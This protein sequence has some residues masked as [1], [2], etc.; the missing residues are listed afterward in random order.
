MGNSLSNNNSDANNNDDFLKSIDDIA[1]N[2]IFKQNIVDMLRFSDSNYRENFIILTC[3]LLDKKLS[4]VDIEIIKKRVLNEDSEN[5]INNSEIG[6]MI[7][8]SEYEKLKKNSLQN[9]KDKKKALLIIA[10][11]YVKIITLFSSIVSVI[12]PQYTYKDENGENNYFYLKDFDDLKMID[13]ETKK[14]KLYHLEN[15]LSLVKKRLFIL[16]NKLDKQDDDSEYVVLNPG[17]ELCTMN[18][19]ENDEASFKLS[20]EIGIKELDSLYYDLYDDESSSWNGRSKEMEQKYKEDVTLFYQI[21]TGKKNKPSKIKSFSDIELLDF[22][23]LKRCKNNDYFEDLLI[24]KNDELFQKYLTKIEEIQQNTSSYKKQLLH[25]LKSIFQKVTIETE[26]GTSNEYKIHPKLNMKKL[27]EKQK[28]IKNCIV[29]MY[30]NCEKNFIEALLIYEKMYDNRYGE[31]VDEQINNM[32]LKNNTNNANANGSKYVVDENDNNIILNGNLLKSKIQLK[33]MNINSNVNSKLKLNNNVIKTDLNSSKE[34]V[35]SSNKNEFDVVPNEN[36]LSTFNKNV[37]RELE[38]VSPSMISDNNSSLN[39]LQKEPLSTIN[40]PEESA[41]TLPQQPSMLPQQP[42]ILPQQPSMLPQ[43]PSMLPQQPSMLPQQ[44]SMLPQQPTTLAEPQPL[45][46]TS[47]PENSLSLNNETK[48][49]SVENMSEPPPPPPSSSKTNNNLPEPQQQEVPLE[50]F[51][52]ADSIKEANEE[53]V[54]EEVVNEEVV[55][56]ETANEEVVNEETANEESPNEE[57]VNEG[58]LNKENSNKEE[59]A[60]PNVPTTLT[61]NNAN[62]QPNN[63]PINNSK[64]IQEKGKQY[65]NNVIKSI[66]DFFTS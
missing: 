62:N 15:P 20:N 58:D 65:Q 35:E 6:K 50:P 55:D 46:Q 8:F 40:K 22:H 2:Y 45:L 36:N 30:S 66:K 28:Q 38:S 13:F 5:G 32:N 3:H 12:D 10:K 21:F 29:N 33:E 24:S 7:Y 41:P 63:K 57:I 27:L 43:Q 56:E 44:P 11:F 64:M 26:E 51:Q 34:I 52:T 25:I 49:N 53:V 23:N 18:I 48:K 47:P 31:L 4:N 54:N 39:N 17:E 9:E 19:P 14:L 60:E 42:S 59:S 61:N 37:D 16:K 1:T